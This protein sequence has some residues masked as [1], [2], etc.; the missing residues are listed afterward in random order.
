MTAHPSLRAVSDGAGVNLLPPARA[1]RDKLDALQ[2]RAPNLDVALVFFALDLLPYITPDHRLLSLKNLVVNNG[3]IWAVPDNPADYQPVLYEIS[4]GGIPAIAPNPEAL[5][6]N[7]MR[8]ANN[9]LNAIEAN[10]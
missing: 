10:T 4:L 6:A 3:G 5:P 8:A 2:E 1:H 9:T 7:W